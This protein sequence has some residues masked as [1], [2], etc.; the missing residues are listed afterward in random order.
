MEIF[1]QNQKKISEHNERYEKQQT[2][3]KMG[4]NKYSDLTDDEFKARMN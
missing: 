4:L 1:L 3:Y 2:S